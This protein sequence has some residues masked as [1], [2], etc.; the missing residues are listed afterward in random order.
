MTFGSTHHRAQLTSS[1]SSLHLKKGTRIYLAALDVCLPL[2][3]QLEQHFAFGNVE[4]PA[5]DARLLRLLRPPTFEH[6]W[7]ETNIYSYADVKPTPIQQQYT[8][9]YIIVHFLASFASTSESRL[10]ILLP[11]HLI[12]LSSIHHQFILQHPPPPSAK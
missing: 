5:A 7:R 12:A 1:G 9:V 11:L 4:E 2:G 3:R 6:I 8:A 10:V